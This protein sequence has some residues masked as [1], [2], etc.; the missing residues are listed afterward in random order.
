MKTFAKEEIDDTL[1]VQIIVVGVGSGV[2]SVIDT[3]S[4]KNIRGLNTLMIDTDADMKPII[5]RDAALENYEDIKNS[6]KNADIVLIVTALGGG[7][8]TGASPVVAKIAKELGALTISII[9]KPFK[10]EGHKRIGHA[11]KGLVALQKESDSVMLIKHDKRLLD[12]DSQIRLSEAFEIM[13]SL[14]IQA[15]NGIVGIVLT[16]GENDINLDFA[17]LKTILND[18]CMASMGLS[19]DEG[20]SIAHK[21]ISEAMESLQFDH[22]STKNIMGVLVHFKVHPDYPMI[23]I[24]DAM[25]IIYQNVHEDADVIFGTSTDKSLDVE[26]LEATVIVRNPERNRIGNNP[27]YNG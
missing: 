18:S 4:K 9:T 6:L 16:S 2:C 1:G 12:K 11:E 10:F 15:I 20:K 5:G 26:Y 3:I 23:D 25:D 7:T 17:D 27:R 13:D 24:C 22:T 8:G 19:N 14:F 21:V